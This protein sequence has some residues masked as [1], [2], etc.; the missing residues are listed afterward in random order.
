MA[1]KDLIKF[2]DTE[3]QQYTTNYSDE[4]FKEKVKK[5]AKKAGTEIIKYAL[6]LYEILKSSKT[7]SAQKALIIGA[8]GYLIL[9]VDIIPDVFPAI[10]YIDDLGAL[11][12]VYAKVKQNITSDIEEKVN[13][14]ISNIFK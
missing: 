13:K 1:K 7:P 10:G 8:L 9:P 12:F 4:D 11:V 14:Q 5:C 2:T 3:I 6:T